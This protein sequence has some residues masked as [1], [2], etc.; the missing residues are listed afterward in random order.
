MEVAADFIAAT[1]PATASMGVPK[2]LYI[3]LTPT[4]PISSIGVI[5]PDTT[6]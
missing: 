3:S 6:P 4:I 2:D 1:P 5:S